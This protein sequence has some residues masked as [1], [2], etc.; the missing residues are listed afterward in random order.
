MTSEIEFDMWPWFLIPLVLIAFALSVGYF[1]SRR[2]RGEQKTKAL[3]EWDSQQ[4][5]RRLI[6]S[7]EGVQALYSRLGYAPRLEWKLAGLIHDLKALIRTEIP[8]FEVFHSALR[9]ISDKLKKK[10]RD[11][12]DPLSMAWAQKKNDAFLNA[13]LAAEDDP[14][15]VLELLDRNPVHE[16]LAF[17]E[18]LPFFREGK[19]TWRTPV[20]L[21]AIRKRPG[22]STQFAQ[23]LYEIESLVRMSQIPRNPGASQAILEEIAGLRRDLVKKDAYFPT[24]LK[25]LEKAILAWLHNTLLETNRSQRERFD[26]LLLEL[27]TIRYEYDL[28]VEPRPRL[29]RVRT[30]AFKRAVR[31][32]AMDYLNAPWMHIQGL[33]DTFLVLLIDAELEGFGR[34]AQNNAFKPAGVLKIVREEIACGQYNSEENIRRFQ[35]QELKGFYLNSLV[36]SLLRLHAL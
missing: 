27:L 20:G 13:V 2:R 24:A 16:P 36:Y 23:I 6:E 21:S 15:R 35:Q 12:A 25:L 19:L 22:N 29:N 11:A 1:L 26:R 18:Q 33:T 10:D 17:V 4:A 3:Q 28:D 9:N 8:D 31:T 7:N 5:L 30:N 32:Q 34:R 14:D